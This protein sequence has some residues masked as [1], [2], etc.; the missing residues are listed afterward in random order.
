MSQ[1]VESFIRPLAAEGRV[2][3]MLG[4][5]HSI[6]PPCVKA[7]G[8]PAFVGL[9]AHMDFRDSY[10]GDR[11]S[12]ACVTRRVVELVGVERAL[13]VGVR[14]YS[15]P[16]AEA[17]E[18]MGLNYITSSDI[19][20]GGL[21]M[22]TEAL[23]D[24]PEEVYVSLDMDAV[25]P[26]YAPAVGNP[27]PFGLTPLHVKQII[28]FLGGRMVGFDVTEVSPPWDQ[29]TTAALAARIVRETLAVLR[30]AGRA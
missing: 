15:R 14:S 30:K 6:T 4:G 24:L 16:E 28:G 20:E 10:L 23:E 29:G 26:A 5:E 8:R 21:K 13:V 11:Y 12:H 2:T 9:D 17:V 25:D 22:V 27:E 18:E 1:E 3:L 7:H 19:V